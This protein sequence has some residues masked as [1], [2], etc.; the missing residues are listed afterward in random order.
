MDFAVSADHGVKTR[1]SERRDKYLDI[2]GELKKLWY[3]KMTVIPIV[4]GALG[5]DTKGL[6]QGLEDL[7][8]RGREKTS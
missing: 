5:T 7:E 6:I 4:I 3:M 8:I 2:A 1:E